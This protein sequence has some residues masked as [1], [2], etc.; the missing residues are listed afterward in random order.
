MKKINLEK[1]YNSLLNDVYEVK[2]PANIA[3]KAKLSIARML[4]VS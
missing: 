3:E 4:E 2:V 1:I